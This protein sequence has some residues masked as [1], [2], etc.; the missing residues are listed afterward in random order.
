MP[1][2][3]IMNSLIV[4][5]YY[6]VYVCARTHTYA[7]MCICLEIRGQLMGVTSLF[8]LS[9]GDPAQV[10]SFWWQALLIL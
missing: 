7:H 6:S 4:F 8:P 5:I 2:V 9:T 1:L 3:L 10:T